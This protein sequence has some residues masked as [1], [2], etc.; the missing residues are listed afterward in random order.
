MQ[1]ALFYTRVPHSVPVS[2]HVRTETSTCIGATRTVGLIMEVCII[3]S[4]RAYLDS[5]H[6]APR[7][8][9]TPRAA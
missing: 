7:V 4:I 1:F 5:A 2:I 8:A 6:R 3:V 9:L